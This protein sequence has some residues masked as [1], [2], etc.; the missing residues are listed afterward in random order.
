MTGFVLYRS[1]YHFL[2]LFPFLV[3]VAGVKATSQTFSAVTR[4]S[5]LF[6]DDPIDGILGL[7]FQDISNLNSVRIIETLFIYL[8]VIQFPFFF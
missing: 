7:A 6:S 1:P 3:T 8:P 2:F 5:D 4:L